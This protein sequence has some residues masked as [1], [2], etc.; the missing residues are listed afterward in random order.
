M[1]GTQIK[2]LSGAKIKQSSKIK[3]PDYKNNPAAHELGFEL[4]F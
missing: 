4:G 2:K 3:R 1:F